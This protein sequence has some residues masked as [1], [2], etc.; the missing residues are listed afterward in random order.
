LA[1]SAFDLSERFQSPVFV[2]S[3]LDLAMNTWMSDP[4][5]YPEGEI[6]RGK[7]LTPDTLKKIGEWGRYKDVDGDGIPYRTLPGSG[8][9]AYF[10]RGS[11]HNDKGQYSERPDDFVNNLNRL[12]RKFD[13]ARTA[14]PQPVVD[15]HPNAKIGLIGYGTSHWAIDE[16]RDQLLREADLDTSY[17]RLRAYPFSSALAEFIDQHDRIYVIEQNRDAQMLGLMRQELSAAHIAKLRSV[18][19]YNGLPIDARSVTDDILA[20]EGQALAGRQL[21]DVHEDAMGGV[22][23]E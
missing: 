11:G 9:P 2:L 1:L 14:V 8:M 23:G 7:V 19:H 16:S 15:R 21:A 10:T 17:F 5:A 22:G 6:D 12:A 18:L 20:Q 13:T 4:F 3:E